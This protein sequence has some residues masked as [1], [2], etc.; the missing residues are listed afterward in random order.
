MRLGKYIE[1]NETVVNPVF[2]DEIKKLKNL[3][4]S[5]VKKRF[6]DGWLRIKNMIDNS[7]NKE[8]KDSVI[9]IINKYM[10]TNYDSLD[11]VRLA[12]QESDELN[13]DASHWWEIVKGEAFPTLSFYPALQCWLELD[14]LLKGNGFD[15]RVMLVY[16]IFWLLL[17]SGKYIK[18]W[19]EW[20]KNNPDEYSAERALGKGGIV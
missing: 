17:I 10:K 14:K 5:Q 2:M 13:E 1:L 9:M 20:K 6:S 11:D 8:L 12:L 19:I 4:W 3:S 16:A 7:D 18:G 15:A